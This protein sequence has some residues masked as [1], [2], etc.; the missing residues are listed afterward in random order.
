HTLVDDGASINASAIQAGDGG[1]VVV[2]S[3]HG[4]WY[5]GDIFARGGALAGNGGV[6]EVSG[7]DFLQF[8]GTADRLAPHGQA[9]MLLLDPTNLT[10]SATGPSDV[11]CTPGNC[12]AAT[13]NSTLTTA[14]LQTALSGGDVNVDSTAGTGGAPLGTINW[15]DGSVDAGSHSLTLTGTSI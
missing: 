15:T 6:V 13:T 1:K 5:Y 9:G 7:K 4:T 10:I 2:W 3:D 12:S 11:T 14:A 8:S